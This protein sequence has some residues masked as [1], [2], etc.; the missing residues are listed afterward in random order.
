MRASKQ[1]D[2]ILEILRATC[3]HPSA[4]WI[5]E[6][7]RKELPNISL[8]TVYRNL[9]VLFENGLVDELS[10]GKYPSRYEIHTQRHHHIRCENCGRVDDVA[11]GAASRLG[12][13]AARHSRYEIIDHHVQI[14]GLCPAC[15][16]RRPT[17]PDA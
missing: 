14:L 3:D 11:L 16:Q 6:Q 2:V 9:R 4:D 7:A 17:L 12:S 15:Q 5:Y 1:K 13:E 8:G 10:F